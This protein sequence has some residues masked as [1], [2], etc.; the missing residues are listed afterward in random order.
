[1]KTKGTK[2][3]LAALL[4]LC[5]T[6]F[7]VPL[8]ANAAGGQTYSPTE[9]NQVQDTINS[10]NDGDTLNLH[11]MTEWEKRTADGLTVTVQKNITI[12]AN[13]QTQ[14]Y[15][16]TGIHFVLEN[17]D[18]TM[19]ELRVENDDALPIISGTGNLTLDY[20]NL[21]YG[22]YEISDAV[23]SQPEACIKLAGDVTVHGTMTPS[24]IGYVKFTTW[25][26]GKGFSD[27]YTGSF[28]AGN[29]IEANNVTIY[30]GN[31]DGGFDYSK[32]VNGGS[33]IVAKG[34][35]ILKGTPV[36]SDVDQDIYN[37]A[38]IWG[39]QGLNGG[40]AIKAGGNVLIDGGAVCGGDAVGASGFGGNAV[41]AAGN[42]TIIGEQMIKDSGTFFTTYLFSGRGTYCPGI[43]IVLTGSE[44]TP[45]RIL[46]IKNAQVLGRD[47]GSFAAAYTIDMQKNDI[48][49]IDGSKIG[50][51][52]S[53]PIFSG[54]SY[55]ITN[56]FATW[57]T[58][59]NAAPV[60]AIDNIVSPDGKSTTITAT[61][62][63]PSPTYTVTIPATVDAGDLTQKAEA[64]ADKVKSTTFSVSASSVENLFGAKKV[65]VSLSTADGAFALKNG[66]D[67]LEYAVYNQET[68]GTALTSGADFT[69]FTSATSV[70]GRVDID[71][72]KIT[73][74]GSYTGTMT[75]SISLADI[76]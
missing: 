65:V 35:V 34:D 58:M 62:N 9:W 67:S 51:Y 69:E 55:Q 70:T 46:R 18:V 76:V 42:V 75:F 66:D 14:L 41:K 61:A 31:I 60:K 28:D 37:S 3:G 33:A 72:S 39:G 38:A 13:D 59:E 57:G 63:I 6:L 45:T 20:V 8:T 22:T 74:K 68:G 29:A 21:G 15:A 36:W 47:Q 11:A 50:W 49:V 53:I 64:D 52:G 19:R 44:S 30:G 10:M 1:M 71:Q 32:R 17:A 54:G 16:F 73:K 2:R 23:D 56:P 27:S 43:P 7:A 25:V 4:V 24:E 40:H 12:T 5:M 48:A 26:K